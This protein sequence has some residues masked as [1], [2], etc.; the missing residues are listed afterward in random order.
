MSWDDD[1][2]VA[3]FGGVGYSDRTKDTEGFS[4]PNACAYCGSDVLLPASLFR[5]TNL[6]WMGD[7]NADTER[8]WV[9]YDTDALIDAMLQANTR[10]TRHCTTAVTNSRYPIPRVVRP[11]RKR[12]LWRT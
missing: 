8:E 4:S 6:N 5:V 9:D 10:P 12:F 1:G 2:A 11:W 7:V 3:L